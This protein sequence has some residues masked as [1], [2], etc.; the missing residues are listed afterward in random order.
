MEPGLISLLSFD[1][2]S[3]LMREEAPCTQT[4]YNSREYKQTERQLVI[5][6]GLFY[7]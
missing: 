1:K 3:P 7:W 2:V 4:G 5:A 6:M